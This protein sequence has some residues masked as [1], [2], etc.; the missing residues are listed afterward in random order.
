VGSTPTALTSQTLVN[1][2]F[3]DGDR[4]GCSVLGGT[5]GGTMIQAKKNPAEAGLVL[6]N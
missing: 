4:F 1:I 6:G 5:I 3:P 2:D